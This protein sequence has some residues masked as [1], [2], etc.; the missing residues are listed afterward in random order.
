MKRTD[1]IALMKDMIGRLEAVSSEHDDVM[2]VTPILEIFAG[3]GDD[4]LPADEPAVRDYIAAMDCRKARHFGGNAESQAF[5]MSER[6][7]GAARVIRIFHGPTGET[8]S[9]RDLV[10]PL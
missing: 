5:I 7:I 3:P 9:P 6:L 1:A 4:M 8:V 2:R 10:E